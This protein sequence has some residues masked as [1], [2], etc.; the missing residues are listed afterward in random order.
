MQSS[1]YAVVCKAESSS[2]QSILDTASFCQTM[3]VVI[4]NDGQFFTYTCCLAFSSHFALSLEKNCTKK[5]LS[6]LSQGLHIGLCA[7]FFCSSCREIDH[8]PELI[9]NH[10]TPDAF[11]RG[12][13][14]LPGKHGQ[15]KDSGCRLRAKMYCQH[16]QIHKHRNNY[17]GRSWSFRHSF[18]Y[19]VCE[20]IPQS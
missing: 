17:P 12:L 7:Q 3:N 18:A 20:L 1:C 2:L 9:L 19:E 11:S 10:S 16:Q 6:Y 4:A 8:T 14:P 13:C 5:N 15:H